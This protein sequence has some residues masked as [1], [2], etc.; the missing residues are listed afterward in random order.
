[1]SLIKTLITLSLSALIILPAYAVGSDFDLSNGFDTLEYSG[2]STPQFTEDPAD[3][4]VPAG[5][6]FNDDASTTQSQQTQPVGNPVVP[7]GSASPTTSSTSTA[8]SNFNYKPQTQYED[9]AGLRQYAQTKQGYAHLKRI[10]ITKGLQGM[11]QKKRRPGFVEN[12]TPN[13]FHGST[14]KCSLDRLTGKHGGD[15]GDSPNCIEAVE[16]SW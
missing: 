16:N 5:S 14:W 6:A 7:A 10:V 3:M 8:F 15:A 4:A 1:M 2:E 12:Y 11:A 9:I 13:L